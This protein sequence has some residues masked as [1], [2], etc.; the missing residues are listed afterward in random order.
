MPFSWHSPDSRSSVSENSENSENSE[1]SEQLTAD[2]FSKISQKFDFC[3]NL[4]D[5]LVKITNIKRYIG[6]LIC[7]NFASYLHSKQFDKK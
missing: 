4:L 6:S 1:F 2:K 7:C 5:Y 3:T